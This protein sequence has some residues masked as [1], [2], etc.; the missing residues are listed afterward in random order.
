MAE[1]EHNTLTDG[2]V[3]VATSVGTPPVGGHLKAIDDTTLGQQLI[4]GVSGSYKTVAFVPR[5]L[6]GDPNSTLTSRCANDLAIDTSST[7]HQLWYAPTS[8][9]T[10]WSQ[11]G[12]GRLTGSGSSSTPSGITGSFDGHLLKWNDTNLNKYQWFIWDANTST[13]NAITAAYASGGGGGY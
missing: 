8:G 13:W 6:N 12:V 11:I 4:V 10:G 2:I 7:P 1:V 5:S 3:A 9:S